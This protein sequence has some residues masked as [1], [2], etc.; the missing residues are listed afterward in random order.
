MGGAFS[1]ILGDFNVHFS[2]RL[3]GDFSVSRRDSPP[4]GGKIWQPEPWATARDWPICILGRPDVVSNG[5]V[6]KRRK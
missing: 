3:L 1:A 2:S 5:G 6:N 4:L